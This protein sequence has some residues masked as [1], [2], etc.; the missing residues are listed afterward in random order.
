MRT[1]NN[2]P[3]RALVIEDNR[4]IAENI[5]D[6]LEADEWVLDFAY[7]GIGGLHLALTGE[8]DVLILDLMLPGMD[9]IT[10]CRKYREAVK[11]DAPV[12]MLTARDALSDKL[13]GFDAGADDYLVKPF[14]MEELEARLH[15]LIKR[16]DRKKPRRMR[17]GELELNLGSMTVRRDGKTIRLNKA[18]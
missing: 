17:V 14:A 4:D 9:G 2:P 8:Y 12:L 13:E 5:A 3:S 1:S 18:C 6:Y 7:D 16:G 11:K 10:L 15:A